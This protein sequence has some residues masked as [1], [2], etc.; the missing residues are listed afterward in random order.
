MPLPS[1]PLVFP[2]LLLLPQLVSSLWPHLELLQCLAFGQQQPLAVTPNTV[3]SL[4][5]YWRALKKS[6]LSYDFSR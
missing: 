4:L 3:C 1:H 6:C 5:E 2:P